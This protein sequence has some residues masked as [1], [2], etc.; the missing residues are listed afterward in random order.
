M[1]WGGL[2]QRICVEFFFSGQPADEF[3]FPGQPA[4]QFSLI[5]FISSATTKKF[6]G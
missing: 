4:D 3:L 6:S 5:N 2:G 1:I